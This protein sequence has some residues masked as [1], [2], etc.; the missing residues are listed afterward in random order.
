MAVISFVV[1][2]PPVP[3]GRPRLTR[4]GHAYTPARTV[5]FERLVRQCATAAM[6]GREPVTGRLAVA[7]DFAV[8][9]RRRSDIDNLA[10]GVLD[11]GNGVLWADDSQ[12]AQLTLR[13]EVDA[14]N[15]H[16][17]V[18]VVQEFAPIVWR[19]K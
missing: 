12:I 16:T 8:P 6:A 7:I 9:D 2:G 5:A 15:P 19:G 14:E 4:T 10:K 17:T 11:A 13:R 3:K 1:P 18:T